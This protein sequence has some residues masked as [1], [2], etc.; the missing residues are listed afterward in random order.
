MQPKC[1][2][3]DEWIKKMK[4]TYTMEYYSATN[5]NEILPSAT[6]WMDVKSIML[7]EIN[8]T[9]KENYHMISFICEI[10]KTE[11]TKNTVQYKNKLRL[12]RT[13]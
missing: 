4:N 12:Q 10:E 7:S 8:Q 13:D 6:T 3:R 11:Q 1:P 2:P 5:K 9:Q